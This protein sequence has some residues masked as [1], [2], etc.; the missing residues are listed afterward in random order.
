MDRFILQKSENSKYDWICVDMFNYI[1]V[2]FK[3][4]QFNE[5]QYFRF[6]EDINSPDA[7]TLAKCANEMAEWLR[8]NH[9]D[10]IF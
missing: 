2:E 1:V 9:Y 3:N 5:T 8:Y 10:K 4:K 7:L 6:L